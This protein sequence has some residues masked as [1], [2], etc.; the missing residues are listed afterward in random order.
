MNLIAKRLIA[1][2]ERN[3]QTSHVYIWGAGELGHTI[4]EWLLQNRTDCQLLGFIETS[5]KQTSIQIMQS[6]L[7]V[8][9]FDSARLSEEHY[10]IIASQAFEREIIANIYK[11]APE[12]K[13]KI[14]S[15]SQYKCWLKKQIED[16]VAGNEIKKLTELLFDYPEEYQLWLA[17]AELEIDES[18]K[19]DYL[20]CA[21]ALSES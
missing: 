4:G 1:N 3:I 12:F 18:I 15:Y 16:L 21:Q 13:S 2:I 17:M 6:Q 20:T 8:Y 11:V 14:I 9:S 7:P 5:P 10:L 19:D